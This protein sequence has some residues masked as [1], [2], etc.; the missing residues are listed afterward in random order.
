MATPTIDVR[1]TRLEG[2]AES[3]DDTLRSILRILERMDQQFASLGADVATLKTDAATLTSDMATLKTD[4]ATLKKDMGT[5]KADIE[6]LTTVT[7]VL[8]L[9]V[10]AIESTTADTNRR[11]RVRGFED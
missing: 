2:R 5:A 6:T 1:V 10:A 7:D 9:K 11:V 8:T 4:V 3:D